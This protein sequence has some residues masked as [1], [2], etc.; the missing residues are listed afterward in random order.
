VS[1]LTGDLETSRLYAGKALAIAKA[2]NKTMTALLARIALARVAFQMND[3]Q[4]CRRHLY[5]VIQGATPGVDF[6]ALV[7]AHEDLGD[8]FAWEEDY[9]QAL[10]EYRKA[11]EIVGDSAPSGE[12][13]GE[14]AWRIGVCNLHGGDLEVAE[15]HIHRGL[16][17]CRKNGDQKE[18]ALTIRAE[19]LLLIAQ[20]RP[21]EAHKRF[22]ESLRLLERLSV[23]FEVA[24]AHIEIA[25]FLG[26]REGM[27][28]ARDRHM[29][30]AASLF[31]QCQ[32]DV[33]IRLVER[34]RRSEPPAS[35]ESTTDE[36]LVITEEVLG[37][38]TDID[39]ADE[40]RT[41]LAAVTLAVSW[42]SE[43][44]RKSLERI[45]KLAPGS[46]PILISGESGAGKSAFAEIAHALG[47][48]PRQPLVV[49]NCASLPETLLES[50]LFGYVRGA[51]TG[52]DSD[53]L[54]LI[55]AA[56]S[57]TVF[58]DEIDKASLSLQASLLHVLDRREIRSVGS[59]TYQPVRARFLF[60]T[61]KDLAAASS[62]GEFLADLTYR[63]SGLRVEVPPLRE[64]LEDFDLLLGLALR[65]LRLREGLT[66]SIAHEARD[67]L[68]TYDWPGNIRELFGIV[69]AAAYFTGPDG[70]IGLAQ[71]EIAAES[72][73]LEKGTTSVR[74]EED[75][76]TR[77]R[78]YEKDQ[79]LRTVRLEGGNQTRAAARLGLTRRGLNKKLH[80]HGLLDQ[81][82]R[83]G[84]R[85]F[86]RR[87][88]D[89]S[90]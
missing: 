73:G 41:P 79:L 12:L 35:R 67:L 70:R 86:R 88:E 83:E 31:A 8:L 30:C 84:L 74:S 55:R 2:N 25:R 52:A 75:L 87:A 65:D 16:D 5:H 71:L 18:L 3:L 80:R 21:E 11:E 32:S 26:I 60:A 10:T 89:A 42:R 68:T 38:L 4:A 82:A 19:A 56:R 58:L 69:Q 17:V 64:R 85:D 7:L 49:V 23:P 59:H 9:S 43:E 78:E 22:E 6:L 47:R 63:V 62:K 61:N 66:I 53:K 20:G 76:A 28:R 27:A 1:R 50:E 33:G 37:D 54:G 15:S 34:L 44:F 45:E 14:L 13:T 81:L 57:G 51:F 77:V 29:E 46:Q 36:S 72:S 39:D 40:S 24:R 90:E 48:N